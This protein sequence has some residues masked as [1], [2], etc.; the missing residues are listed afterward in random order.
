MNGLLEFESPFSD[1]FVQRLGWL[2]IHSLWQFGIVALLAGVA[3][4][5]MRPHSAAMRYGVL[6]IAMAVSVVA[7]LATW[8]LQQVDA[9]SP[10]VNDVT[11]V[12]ERSSNAVFE[13]ATDAA[14][15]ADVTLLASDAETEVS[16][17]DFTRS[18]AV[19]ATLPA[20][21][22]LASDNIQATPNWSE[23]AESV[24]RPWMAWIVAAWGSG[25]A[26][27]SARPLLGWHTLQRLRR[28]G[29]SPVSDEV[30]ASMRRVSE[31]LGVRR[32]VRVFQSTVAQ[33]PVVVGYMRP[34][35]LLPLSLITSIPATQLEAILAHELAH[36]GRHDFVVNLLQTLVE[37]L[38]FYHPAVWWLSRQIRVEREHCCDD[39]VVKLF[40][41]RVEYGRA[42]V[43]VEELR[44]RKTALALGASDGSLLSRVRRIA[45]VRLDHTVTGPST[46]WP[47]ALAGLVTLGLVVTIAF[48][49]PFTSLAEGETPLAQDSS[50][51]ASE[52]RPSEPT[53]DAIDRLPNSN[54]GKG[55]GGN[56]QDLQSGEQQGQETFAGSDSPRDKPAANPDD[57]MP[58]E[59]AVPPVA[60]RPVAKELEPFQG[61]WPMS[62]CD[63]EDKTLY[64]PQEVIRHW[65]WTIKGDEILWQRERQVWKLTFKVDPT[66]SPKEIDLTY[67]DGPFKGV[68]CLGMYEWGGVDGK[69]LNISIQ[70]PGATVAR[71]TSISMTGGGQTSLIFLNPIDHE[72]EVSQFQGTWSVKVQS[73]TWPRPF[74]KENER[75]WMV[76]GNEITWTSLEG[77][78]VKAS[79]TIDSAKSPQQIDLTFLSGPDK[80]KKCLGIYDQVK[81]GKKPLQLC[82]TDPGSEAARPTE[83]QYE[84]KSGRVLIGLDP[85]EQPVPQ[86]AT[87]QESSVEPVAA[88]TAQS[89]AREKE[90]FQRAWKFNTCWSETWRAETDEVRKWRWTVKGGQIA[91]AGPGS[92]EWKLSFTI[93]PSK[94]PKEIDLTFLDGPHQ[95]ER[96]AGIYTTEG[97]GQEMWL[98]LQDPGAKTARP[99]EFP[100]SLADIKNSGRSLFILEPVEPNS[101]ETELASLQGSW[102]LSNLQTQGWPKPIGKGPDPTGQGSKWEW[103]IEGTEIIW[104][105]PENEEIRL[106]FTI[107]PAKSPKCFDVTFLSGPDKGKK[108][109][110]LYERSGM[111]GK[112]LWLCLTDPDSKADRP[113]DLSFSSYQGRSLMILQPIKPPVS[114]TSIDVKPSVDPV[115]VSAK[116]PISKELDSIQGYWAVDSLK[117]EF[118]PLKVSDVDARRWRW[119]I[120]GD[121]IIWGREGQEW[122]LSAKL[123]PSTTPKQIDFTFLDGPNKGETCLGIYERSGDEGK[124]LRIR[125]QDPG[126][127]V[128]RPIDF[129]MKQGSQTSL[130][131]LRSIPP[132]DPVKELASFQGT[133]SWDYSQL[134]TWPQPI[135]VGTDSDG[136][137]SEKRWVIEGNRI[138]WVGRDGQRVYV[139]FTID[140][141]KA[142]KQIEFT[143]LNGPHGGHKSIGIYESKGDDDYRDL[144]MT[145]PGTDAPR[146]TDISAG[147]FKQQSIIAIHRVAP[148]AKPFAADELKRLQGVWKMTL[149]DSTLRTFGATQKEI[150]NWQWTIKGDEILWRRGSDEWR[151]KLEIAPPKSPREMD[152]TYLAAPFELDLTYLTGPFK[153]AKCRGIFGWGGV[154]RQ[155]LMI[156]IQDP[157]SDAPRPTK[158]YMNSAVKTGLMI[159]SPSKPSDIERENAALQ[160]TWTLRNFDTGNFDRNKD[161][162]SWPLPSGKGPDKS[163]EG[164]ELRWRITGNEISWTSRSGQEIKASFTIDSRQ[165]PKQI[166]LTFLSGP[167]KGKTCPGIYQRGDL[168]ENILW[169]CLADPDSTKVRPKEFSYGWNEG[170]SLL[171]LY[172]FKGAAPKVSA[173][174]APS[175]APSP[176]TPEKSISKELAPFDG[177]WAV[178]SL[179]SEAATI[180]ISYPQQSWRW[181]IKGSE[182]VWGREGQQFKLAAKLDPSTSPKQIDFTFLDGPNKGETCPGIY[183]W[184]GD[185]GRNLRIR[186]QDPSAKVG[187]PTNFEM[188]KGSQTSLIVL[189]PIPPV[190]PVKELASFQGTWCFDTLQ[191]RIWP[192][193]IGVGIDGDGRT[194]E[195]RMVVKGNQ[196]TWTDRQGKEIAVS[197]TI[198]PFQTPKQIDFTFLIG[199]HR[200][201]KSLG[202]YEPQMGND[203]FLW[204]CMT[205]PGTNAPRPIDV[206]FSGQKQ[207]SM[208]GMYQVAPPE[209]PSAAKALERF[210]GLWN[211]TLCDS[212]LR[213][214]GATQQEAEKWK[215]TIKGDEVLWSRQGEVWKLKLAVDPSKRPREIDLTYLTGPFQGEKCLGMYEFG[216]I[217]EQSLLIA[218]QDPGAKVPRP[219][220]IEMSGSSQTGF[221]FLRPNQPSDSDRQIGQFQGTWTLRNYDTG[222][223]NDKSSWPIPKGKGPDKSGNGSELRWVVKGN[224]ITWTNKSGEEIKASLTTN[225]E[226]RP[227]QIDLTFLTGPDRGETCPGIYQHGDLDENIL[228]LCLPDPGTKTARPTEFSYQWGAGRSLLSL[229]LFDTSTAQTSAVSKPTSGVEPADLTPEKR[230]AVIETVAETFL[231][232]G[233]ARSIGTNAD[234]EYVRLTDKGEEP[235]K[236]TDLKEGVH[237]RY[238]FV[239]ATKGAAK[240]VILPAKQNAD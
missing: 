227:K 13:S 212:A 223:N 98:C 79:F 81:L 9:S 189:R 73:D 142:P 144:C 46:R 118:A 236:R 196:I 239:S 85:V 91:W 155:D 135:G 15:L 102:L 213:T 119:T 203:N 68:T 96:C 185:N 169:I 206:S 133:W 47:I 19:S 121:E 56:K 12:P 195:Q 109:L 154:D 45:S 29:I 103:L 208:I 153:G 36:V 197:F 25:V 221:I 228:W 187:R 150:E 92:E 140:P 166:D 65:R 72:Y 4:R 136:R 152:L 190:D 128:G 108:C 162:S 224:E 209:K 64:A 99:I 77:D 205:N 95:R 233:D 22:P 207:Q 49:V 160:G 165:R 117:S 143:F 34:V 105:S 182:V 28:V 2:L 21:S 193:P 188:K 83:F 27:C 230:Q 177:T 23:L 33:V 234:T 104:T 101:I 115:P 20:I 58:N 175:D 158:F 141:F 201:A 76:K 78:E 39:L 231:R 237:V 167:D 18:N 204:L 32:V 88:P 202:I 137:K 44:G 178:D 217:D 106:S 120:K 69:C 171:S 176:A 186:M 41:N 24:M 70:D 240:V 145:D 54:N 111:L 149:C 14:Q 3:V 26:L 48:A 139:N 122:R 200:G 84:A 52:R 184:S 124:K 159:L 232:F 114:Q 180:K 17:P 38:F 170:R 112:S 31:R 87:R 198:D 89:I 59:A 219:Q 148:P 163:G 94:S 235:A 67:L 57:S 181:S 10:L 35:I 238:E 229:Y 132:I 199:P 8:M 11:S 1:S 214:Y 53:L 130:L 5:V 134:W 90:L 110:G 37:T 225:P 215:W 116:S 218:I 7:P 86:S 164:S 100:G 157:G 183:E 127:K 172:P 60:E 107:D 174:S 129:E 125:I 191:F 30:L 42:L 211:V 138:T 222:R 220:A 16:T 61:T 75:R 6:L 151:L 179:D 74:G 226:K 161:P 62:L 131:A 210:Q 82:L 192:E 80:G 63:S 194:S 71:P 168:D 216:G 93:D 55:N 173:I 66:K 156:A 123:D 40:G 126:A 43:A 147:T 50:D 146:P 51:T 97:E 113:A